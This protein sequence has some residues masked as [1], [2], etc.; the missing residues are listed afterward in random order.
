MAMTHY[1]KIVFIGNEGAGK[2]SLLQRLQYG[3]FNPHTATTIGASF[4]KQTI[5]V[6]DTDVNLHFWDTTGQS[7]FNMILPSFIR[8]AKIVLICFDSADVDNV[9]NHINNVNSVDPTVRIILVMTKIDQV[10]FHDTKK[11]K[12]YA[13]TK[14]LSVFLTSAK[15]GEGVQKLFEEIAR[16]FISINDVSP[17]EVSDEDAFELKTATYPS[18]GTTSAFTQCCSIL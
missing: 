5:C 13:L 12:E 8:G 18:L 7:R 6:D 15:S 4:V 9:Q 10:T 16:Y 14:E 3:I 1:K 11:I 2:T 17:D